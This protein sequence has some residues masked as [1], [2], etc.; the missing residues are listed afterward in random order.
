MQK[1]ES[2]E[3][4]WFWMTAKQRHEQRYKIWVAVYLIGCVLIYFGIPQTLINFS[5]THELTYHPQKDMFLTLLN[6]AIV[7]IGPVAVVFLCGIPVMVAFGLW[8]SCHDFYT[9]Y[10]KNRNIPKG[11]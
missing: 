6:A 10:R 5:S 7:L 11:E 2:G 9:K 4:T 3:D 1:N 8:V